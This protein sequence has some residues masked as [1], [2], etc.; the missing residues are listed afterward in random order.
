M[1]SIAIYLGSLDSNQ[2]LA[3]NSMTNLPIDPGYSQVVLLA[4]KCY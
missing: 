2:R 3:K 4:S 1:S